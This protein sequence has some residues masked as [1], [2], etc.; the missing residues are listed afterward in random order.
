MIERATGSESTTEKGGHAS[1][2]RKS[3][4]WLPLLLGLALFAGVVIA[5]RHASE[6]RDFALLAERAQPWWFGLAVVLQVG[7]YG[8]EGMVY[9]TVARAGGAS[10]GLATAFR[11]SLAKL[12]IDQA[13]PSAGWSGTAVL[14][15]AL[16]R[17]GMPR[18]VVA[19]GIVVD[20]S[21]YYA[22]YVLCLTMALVIIAIRGEANTIVVVVCLA[23]FVF[24]TTLTVL[25]LRLAGR[26]TWKVPPWL[27]KIGILRIVVSFVRD[28]NPGL[29]RSPVLLL[30][31]TAYQLG[32]I[33]CDTATIWVLIRSL[34]G[35]G[36]PSSVFASFMISSLFRTIGI[37]PGGLGTFEAASVL[38][39]KLV[40]VPIAMALAATLLFRG[41][42]FWL[43]MLPGIW[44]SR[45]ARG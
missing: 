28:A 44:F 21:S 10:L 17:C 2:V 8:A 42:S 37:I 19:A 9:R 16:Q 30:K 18:P 14:T 20:L 24:A 39:L 33:L 34:G 22:A 27:E 31:A 25:I 5:V 36:A 12:F 40:G 3:L 6:V 11:L 41:L 4:R 38:T 26:G 35:H 43:P 13:V 1:S 32:I 7:T 15:S 29:A 45:A 23:F